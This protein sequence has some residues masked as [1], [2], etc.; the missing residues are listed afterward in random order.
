ME[1]QE[2]NKI[3]CVCKKEFNK[4]SIFKH[5]H[6]PANKSCKEN[7]DKAKYESLMAAKRQS[8]RQYNRE[9]NE[10]HGPKLRAREKSNYA[11]NPSPAKKKSRDYYAENKDTISQKR[12]ESYSQN[13]D[14]INKRRRDGYA[15]NPT[16]TKDGMNA[17][18]ARNSE[19]IKKKNKD[20]IDEQSK[21]ARILKFK[22]AIM[23]GPIYVCHSSL[24]VYRASK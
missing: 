17:Y 11:E 7:F 2:E 12:K 6:H 23:E 24:L 4:N 9:Y 21:E 5:L 13:K 20:A 3:K 10:K 8:I 22:R 18:Y 1:T 14:S 16:P 19:K 15:E